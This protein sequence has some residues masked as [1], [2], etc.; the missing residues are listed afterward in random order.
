[1]KNIS[2]K[3]SFILPAYK[4]RFLK[5]A[6]DSILAQTCHDFELVIVD[7]KSPEDLNGILREYSWESSFRLLPDGGS[8][9]TVDGISVRYY[10]NKENIGGRNIVEAWN[11]A[12]SYAEGEWCV[13]ASDDDRYL[14]RYL[15]TMLDLS[16]KYP[17]CDLFHAR[18]AEIDENGE[19]MR[20]SSPRVEHETQIQMVYQRGVKRISQFAAEFIFRRSAFLRIGGFVNFP[21]AWY[22][23]DATWML[24][25]KNGVGCSQE[26]LFEFRWSGENITSRY[27]N[28][29]DKIAAGEKFGSWFDEFYSSL[30]PIT[31]EDVF[32]LKN[33]WY[34]L[35][36][37]ID[38]L[39]RYEVRNVSSF[40]QRLKLLTRTQMPIRRRLYPLV[41][42]RS[43]VS[44]FRA[45]VM[46]IR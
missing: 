38:E 37:Q 3:V 13:L 1:M 29:A 46:R 22:S 21:L 10:Q 30:V 44:F 12:M 27:D 2:P 18:I 42:S 24:L 45:L 41:F 16:R 25:S 23:D 11:H 34:G 36:F 43:G 8:L 26:I 17:R 40:W 4:R 5:E 32:L 20:V 19:W 7:D 9:W 39:I 33:L 6:I 31:K 28:V 15:E 35:H 14:P